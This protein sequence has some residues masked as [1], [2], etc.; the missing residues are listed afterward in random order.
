MERVDVSI[1][2]C[3]HRRFNLLVGAVLSLVD[4]TAS[5]DSY[6]VVVVD[7]DHKPNLEVQK[8]VS[9]VSSKISI[10]YLHESKLG[11]SHARNAGGK[12]AS[13]DYIG[14]MDDDAKANPKYIETFLKDL[15][16]CT[17]D[18]LGGPYY[19]FYLDSKPVW[20]LD[21][22]GSSSL[23][24]EPRYLTSREYLC[25]GNIVFRRV[26]LDSLGW[27]NPNFGMTGKKMS[28]GEETLVMIDAWKTN[29]HLKVYYDPNLFVY[30]LVPKKKM[31]VWYQLLIPFKAQEVQAYFWMSEFE[32]LYVQKK[33]IFI[34][35]YHVLKLIFISFPLLIFRDRQKSPFWQNYCIEKLYRPVSLIGSNYRMSK[36][37]IFARHE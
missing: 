11:L 23:G 3:T 13:S 34:F 7:N 6:E 33:V 30:H 2:I 29:P 5:P 19:P 32:K 25:G 26:L 16:E 28:Y 8:I 10:R 27:F 31:A 18:I 15:H 9:N 37:L 20:F 21:H 17:P 35:L 22:Y 14:Y 24:E 12:H 4:Q 36:D 1:V